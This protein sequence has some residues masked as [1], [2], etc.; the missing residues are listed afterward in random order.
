MRKGGVFDL[1]NNQ[2]LYYIALVCEAKEHNTEDENNQWSKANQNR[3]NQNF[4]MIANTLESLSQ[5]IA[6]LE[7]NMQNIN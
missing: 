6:A 4:G 1:E 5:R 2:A 7:G 3:L